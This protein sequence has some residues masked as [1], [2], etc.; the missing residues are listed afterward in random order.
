MERRVSDVVL[1]GLKRQPVSTRAGVVAAIAVLC[2]LY[3]FVRPHSRAAALA[4][5][6]PLKSVDKLISSATIEGGTLIV[7]EE[8]PGTPD[9]G[10]VRLAGATAEAIGKAVQ[11]G[12]YVENLAGVKTVVIVASAGAQDR[13]VQPSA[14]PFLSFSLSA[15]DLRTAQYESLGPAGVLNLAQTV[16]SN[17]REAAKALAD[18]CVKYSSASRHFC[19]KAEG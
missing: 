5:I 6:T 17:G 7:R 16:Q 3:V 11:R 14:A 2:V 13:P 9:F 8:I 19:S 1:E 4:P 12:G 10:N 15:D 18:Y